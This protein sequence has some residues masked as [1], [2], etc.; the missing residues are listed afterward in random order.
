M[1]VPEGG[2]AGVQD[3]SNVIRVVHMLVHIGVR[4]ADLVAKGQVLFPQLQ[5]G[6]A[7]GV[8]KHRGRPGQVPGEGG[9]VRLAKGVGGDVDGAG[10]LPG[11][12]EGR[13]VHP[14]QQEVEVDG[15][16]GD[17]HREGGEFYP[18][19]PPD[20]AVIPQLG[21]GHRPNHLV[22]LGQANG[23]T[24]VGVEELR[25]G[26]LEQEGGLGQAQLTKTVGIGGGDEQFFGIMILHRGAP[27]AVLPRPAG[28]RVF[29]AFGW[30]M[31]YTGGGKK[32]RH[33]GQKGFLPD[34]ILL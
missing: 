2:G 3:Q 33:W 25:H 8:G 29:L 27:L 14:L 19:H 20:G 23:V 24:L 15:Y 7:E 18:V 26:V 12:E 5:L 22:G 4:G 13:A 21:A 6:A 30:G 1:G 34:L 16:R 11:A 9:G 10:L 32:S 17:L 31:G 28:K